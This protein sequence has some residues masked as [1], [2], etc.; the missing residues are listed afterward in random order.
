MT[1]AANDQHNEETNNRED[2]SMNNS[3]D[4][5]SKIKEILGTINKIRKAQSNFLL[6]LLVRDGMYAL[7]SI[8]DKGQKPVT[9]WFTKDE[10]EATLVKLDPLSTQYPH[11]KEITQQTGK[12][13]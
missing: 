11:S 7:S 1:E 8:S 2:S 9:E 13:A 5:C 12:V 4:N 6:K 3:L 10:M